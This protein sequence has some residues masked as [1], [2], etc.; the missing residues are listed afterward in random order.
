MPP[1]P[2][3]S[4]ASSGAIPPGATL[5]REEPSRP[6]NLVADLLVPFGQA[7][8][9]GVLVGGL[10]AF[11]AARL[12]YRA[13]AELWAGLALATSAAAWLVLL[14][15]TRRLLWAVERLTGR[16]LDKDGKTGKPAERLVI[17]NAGQAGEEGA[18]RAEGERQS[19]FA[20]FVAALPTKGTDARTWEPVLGRASYLEYRDTLLRLKWARWRGRGERRGWELALP[21]AE[22]LRRLA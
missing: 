7:V 13:W 20:S 21:A 2:V 4:A 19:R 14:G 8:A 16:D 3:A 10:V 5:A 11:V 12:G 18:R 17:V 15:Q 1:W 9:T 22:I 6:A